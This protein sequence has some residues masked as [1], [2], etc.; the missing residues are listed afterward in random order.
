M[1]KAKPKA[2]KPAKLQVNLAGA[3]KD[4]APFDANDEDASGAILDSA[5]C[6]GMHATGDM[7]FRIVKAQ[8]ALPEVL[9]HWTRA[10]GWKEWRHA[11][12]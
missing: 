8:D 11:A 7:K 10:D 2:V 4:V 12:H 9:M 5:H 1:P 3:W 6:I